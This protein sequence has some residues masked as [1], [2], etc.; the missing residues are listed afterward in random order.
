MGIIQKIILNDYY[1]AEKDSYQRGR[2][3]YSLNELDP[4][5]HTIE[6]KVWDV[7]NNSSES[8]IDFIVTESE[9]FVIQHLLNYPNPFT[10]NTSFSLN[11][12]VLIR[13]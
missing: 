9:E 12:I 5:S 11:I 7:F 2:V 4:G 3:E 8:S 6:F 13:I 1:E 10:T